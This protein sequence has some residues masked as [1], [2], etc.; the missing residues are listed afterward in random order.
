MK[1]IILL[2]LLV[3]GMAVIVDAQ[4]VITLKNGDEIKAKVT[5]ISANVSLSI[6]KDGTNLFFSYNDTLLCTVES[7]EIKSS[8]IFFSLTNIVYA[9]EI[10]VN[11]VVVEY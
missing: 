11:E 10:R 3:A 4:D 1:K 2:F 9:A 7:A 8:D 6:Q 5:E